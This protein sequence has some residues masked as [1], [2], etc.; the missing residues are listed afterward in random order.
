MSNNKQYNIDAFFAG[1]G[2]IDLGFAQNP[3]FKVLYANEFDE[4][5]RKTYAENFPEVK[6]D[7][8]DITKVK[9]DDIPDCDII[10]G[11]FPCQT[12]SIAGLKKGF[13][14]MRG[15]L[16]FEMLRMIIAKQPK[17]V[18]AENVKNLLYH[19]HGRTFATI[20]KALEDNGYTV[21]YQVM[22]S[23]VYSDIPQNRERVYVVAFKDEK[24]AQAFT[25]PK[26]VEHTKKL[27]E[28]IDYDNRVDEKYYY[29]P[30]RS[31]FDLLKQKIVKHDCA[32]YWG[33]RKKDIRETGHHALPTLTAAMGTGGNNVPMILTSENRI[34]KLT[35]RE[36]FSGQGFPLDYKFPKDLSNA[37][38]YKQAGNSVTVPVIARIANNIAQALKETDND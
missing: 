32:Y 35:P 6:L 23:R 18:F 8:N 27:N 1:V 29:T 5:A 14:D 3:A 22:N 34:R 17:V 31:K 11:G 16:F 20:K 7:G 33:F 24:T 36:T 4:Y 21:K 28:I 19:D 13:A 9:A 37:R 15:T 2:G 30:A 12:F 38:L 10:V 25:F 26:P